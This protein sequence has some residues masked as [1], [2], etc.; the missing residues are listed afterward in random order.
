MLTKADLS[1]LTPLF[2]RDPNSPQ[3]YNSYSTYDPP[4]LRLNFSMNPLLIHPS[5][6]IAYLLPDSLTYESWPSS[7]MSELLSTET[8]AYSPKP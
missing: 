6:D 1:A 3:D 5:P 8:P 7:Q 2:W 4:L